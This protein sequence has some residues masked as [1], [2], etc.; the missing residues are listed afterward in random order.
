MQDQALIW[1]TDDKLQVTTLTARLRDLAKI[2]SSVDPLHVSVLWG[3]NNRFGVAVVAHQWALDGES[4]SFDTSVGGTQYHFEL[5]PLCDLDGRV[6]GVSGRAIA[7]QAQTRVRHD[8][9]RE[10]EHVAGVGTWHEDLRTG[11]VTISSGLAT[12]LGIAPDESSIDIRSFDHPDDRAHILAAIRAQD[13][14]GYRCDHRIVC[15]GARVRSVRER[16]R[17]IIDERGF[18]LARLGTLTDISDLKEREAKLCDL[19]HYDALTGLPNR[20]LLEER[21][22]ASLVRN[23]K[24]DHRTAVL[25]IDLDNFKTINDTFGHHF[26]DQ[27]LVHVGERL[28]RFVRGSD[29]VARLSGDEFVVVI[30][31]LFTDDAALDAARK[32]MRSFDDPF[33]FDGR[34]ISI[35]ASIG[36]ATAPTAG[37]TA[38]DLIAAADDEMYGIKRNG[39]SGVKLCRTTQ[40]RTTACDEKTAACHASSSPD[41]PLYA[42]QQSA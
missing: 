5:E 24:H 11:E 37:S 20:A 2:G 14:R 34:C 13:D 36:V 18:A 1:N 9:L 35:T 31:D 25:F 38:S 40:E 26:G 28:S 33:S 21:L 12:L 6:R 42:T 7:V 8:V 32:I 16:V 39:G 17:T 22:S 10:A 30:D 19:V 23:R 4:L 15:S 41:L 29:L 27:L 3:E